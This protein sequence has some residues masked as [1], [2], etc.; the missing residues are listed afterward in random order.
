MLWRCRNCE[1]WYSEIAIV[2]YGG[3]KIFLHD[4]YNRCCSVQSLEPIVREQ[5]RYV[6]AIAPKPK[7]LPG[8][9][10]PPPP[11][12][13][14]PMRSFWQFRMPTVDLPFASAVSYGGACARCMQQHVIVQ[15][16]TSHWVAQR[17][18]LY[19]HHQR[20][21]SKASGFMVGVA[22]HDTRSEILIAFSRNTLPAAQELRDFRIEGYTIRCYAREEGVDIRRTAGGKKLSSEVVAR[23]TFISGTGETRDTSSCAA[24]KL[25]VWGMAQTTTAPW[26]MTEMV[27]GNL[28]GYQDG[29]IAPSCTGCRQFLAALCCTA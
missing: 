7:A 22:V 20:R 15:S 14:A 4:P 11:P 8:G 5:P 16:W 26:S 28:P 25:V 3:R 19:L 6:E 24:S 10:P 21:V 13:S 18:C 9:A 17:V 29:Q 12:P 27:Y 2:E 23:S 1:R